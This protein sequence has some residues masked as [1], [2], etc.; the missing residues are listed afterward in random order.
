M[1]RC[2]SPVKVELPPKKGQPKFMLVDCGRCPYCDM[3]RMREWTT[4]CSIELANSSS[5][6]FITLTY[7]D[8]H[9]P[10]SEITGEPEVQIK[11]HQL[12]MKR[13]R[14]NLCLTGLRFVM[15]G[16]YGG[17]FGRPHY[18]YVVFNIPGK[19][20]Q[21]RDKLAAA[22]KK[23]WDKGFFTMSQVRK[24]SVFHYMVSYVL[25]TRGKNAGDKRQKAF[26]KTSLRP[27]IGYQYIDK[28]KKW[29]QEDPERTDII[30]PGAN[31]APMPKYYR[32]KIVNPS[33]R[34]NFS[35]K[36]LNKAEIKYNDALKSFNNNAEALE[37][38]Q[39]ADEFN[40]IGFKLKRKN[41]SL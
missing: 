28:Y 9:I 35:H 29:H 27:G 26:F 38:A 24:P 13:L 39:R 4:R 15:C 11:E 3:K 36:L 23:S 41:K 17:K 32:D 19:Y 37:K 30:I 18:H 14:K 1:S 31:T 21:Q 2:Y 22:I 6:W 8:E 12:F 7:N 40:K 20:E 34:E 33:Q 25:Q 10:Y 16:E 5:A